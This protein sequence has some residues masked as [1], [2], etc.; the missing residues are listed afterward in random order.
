MHDQLIFDVLLSTGGIRHPDRLYP[1]R[2]VEALICLLDAIRDS[3]YDSLKKDCLVYYL[4]K[5]HRD[6]REDAF[7]DENCIPPQF[8]LLADAYWHLDNGIDVAVRLS[9]LTTGEM[10]YKF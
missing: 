1:P 2:D 3:T 10:K 7:R 4:I 8:V 9:P 5:F 6:G